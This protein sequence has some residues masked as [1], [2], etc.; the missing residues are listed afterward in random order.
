MYVLADIENEDEK[1]LS[2]CKLSASISLQEHNLMLDDDDHDPC[3]TFVG[4]MSRKTALL[5]IP[6]KSMKPNLS[7]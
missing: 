5:K 1:M 7:P 3:H 6:Y 2:N 4:E